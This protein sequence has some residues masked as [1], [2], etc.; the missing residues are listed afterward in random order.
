MV[1]RNRRLHLLVL[2]ASSLAALLWW[3]SFAVAEPPATAAP[4][5]FLVIYRPG[6]AW[7]QGKPIK[8]QPP[9]EHGKYL[10]GLYAKGAM[11]LAGPFTDDA[12]GA[13]MLEAASDADATAMVKAD[14]AVQRGVFLYEIHPWELVPWEKY[15]KK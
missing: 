5:T 8:Q 15:V 6:P 9:K 11:K 12:G 10:I 14:P 7:V 13:V 2:V 3:R 1:L 4:R